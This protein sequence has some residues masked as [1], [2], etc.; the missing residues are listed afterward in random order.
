[1]KNYSDT[2][3]PKCGQTHFELV[4]DTPKESLQKFYYLRC[5]SCKSFLAAFHYINPS[6]QLE[7]IKKHFRI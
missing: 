3:C 6:D 7:E 4:E 2:K 1:M 5:D